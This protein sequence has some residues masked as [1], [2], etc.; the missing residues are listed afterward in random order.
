MA[1]CPVEACRKASWVEETRR[2]GGRHGPGQ[3]VQHSWSTDSWE[4]ND[5]WKL[6][7]SWRIGSNQDP[8]PI[9]GK[10]TEAFENFGLG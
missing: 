9:S 10:A 3:V 4:E 6:G 5:G 8:F 1:T 7:Q 2:T